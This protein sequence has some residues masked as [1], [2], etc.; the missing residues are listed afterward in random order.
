MILNQR[1]ILHHSIL[2]EKRGSRKRIIFL[3]NVRNEDEK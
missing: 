1:E 3:E 2:N